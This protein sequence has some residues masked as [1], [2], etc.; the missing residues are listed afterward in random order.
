MLTRASLRDDSLFAHALCEEDLSEGVV[1]F[2][3]AG[4]EEVF[5]FEIDFSA[6]QFL[7]EAL[8]E[9]KGRGASCEFSECV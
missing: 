5:A 1:D 9:V 4:V 8:S 2:V 6:A 3:G 7:G